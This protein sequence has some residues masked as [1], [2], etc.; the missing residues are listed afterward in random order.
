MYKL[1]S[2]KKWIS[3][4]PFGEFWW[5][6]AQ[7]GQN[8]LTLHTMMF[9]QI[10]D[11]MGTDEQRDKWLP[12]CK[13]LRIFGC[14]AQTELGHG[15]N[16]AG[17][18]TTATYDKETDEFIIHTPTITATKWWPGEMGTISTHAIVFAQLIIDGEK[19]SPAPFVVRIREENTH[20]PVKG[21]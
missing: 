13:N 18:E 2:E 4:R 20:I 16:I 8:P 17:L 14:Y 11:N 15:S 7:I 10:I 5:F 12:L 19:M 21:V 1:D 3:N 9:T 6:Y